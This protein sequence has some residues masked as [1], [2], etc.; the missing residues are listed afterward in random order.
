VASKAM[1][2]A[3]QVIRAFSEVMVSMEKHGF[4]SHSPV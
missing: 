2:V 1:K 4:V 3:S